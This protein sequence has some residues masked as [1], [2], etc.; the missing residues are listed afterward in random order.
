MSYFATSYQESWDL[1]VLRADERAVGWLVVYYY[2]YGGPHPYTYFGTDMIDTK[3]GKTLT[4]SD[5]VK[6]VDGLS[7]IILE[8]LTAIDDAYVFS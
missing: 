7:Q 3:T 6:D 2:Y 8:N 1:E 4:L 5:V